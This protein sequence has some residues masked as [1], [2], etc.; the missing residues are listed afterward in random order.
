MRFG[1]CLCS[2]VLNENAENDQLFFIAMNQVKHCGPSVIN[3]LGQQNMIAMVNLKAGRRSMALSDF[4]TSLKMFQHGVS[5]LAEGHW[6]K[7]YAL[8]IDLF[9]AAAEAA[10]HCNNNTAVTSY[11]DQMLI[12]AKSFNDK[13][14]CELIIYHC[15]FSSVCLLII[16]KY[17]LCLGMLI[18]AKVLR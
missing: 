16:H 8:S 7:N 14:N 9:N 2:H 12:H 13:L 15:C 1:L 11:S 5:F 10:C 4:N 3:D 6:N 18:M 17:V